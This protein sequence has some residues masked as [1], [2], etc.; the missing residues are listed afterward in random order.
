MQ[1]KVVVLPS[2]PI[3]VFFFKVLVAI[4]SSD[5]KVSNFY[6]ESAILTKML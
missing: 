1:S 2:K 4:A 3:V 6:V 5:R